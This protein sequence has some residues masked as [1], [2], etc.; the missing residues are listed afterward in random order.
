[1]ITIQKLTAT[2]F[3]IGY[4][5]KGAGT[6]ASVFC[7]LCWYFFMP[8]TNLNIIL[9]AVTVLVTTLGIWSANKVEPYWG[10]DSSKVVIDEAAGIFISLLFIP[11]SIKYM[12][13]ALVLFR[14]FDI[15]KILFIRKAENVNGGLG[16]MLDDIVA[17]V[18]SNIILQLIVYFK[19]F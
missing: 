6:V 10:E 15:S 9:L 13:A 19:I 2:F 11:L 3:G 8:Q 5:G 12:F 14:F 18:Y 4:I 17:G 1:M 7:A 16:V